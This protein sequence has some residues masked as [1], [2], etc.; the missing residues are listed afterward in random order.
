MPDNEYRE[1]R[2]KNPYLIPR[3]ANVR[4]PRFYTNE[5]ELVYDQI[6]LD[7]RN[8]VVLQHH[9]NIPHMMSP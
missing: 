5:Q 6:Y 3:Q 8:A 9:L 7:Q 2:M 1:Y 4:N